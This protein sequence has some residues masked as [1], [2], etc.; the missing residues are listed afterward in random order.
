MVKT[1]KGPALKGRLARLV[2]WGEPS[3]LHSRQIVIFLPLPWVAGAR[4]DYAESQRR[5][6]QRAKIGRSAV[7]MKVGPE[8]LQGEGHWIARASIGVVVIIIIV[9]IIIITSSSRS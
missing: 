7:G 3:E 2:G 5:R 9:I 8:T 1:N 4:H 6:G